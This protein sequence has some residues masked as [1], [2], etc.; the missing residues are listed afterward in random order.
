MPSPNY[1]RTIASA[2]YKG[3]PYVLGQMRFD[4][5]NWGTRQVIFDGTATPVIGKEVWL[6]GKDEA[7]GANSN[8]WAAQ[9]RVICPAAGRPQHPLNL[10]LIVTPAGTQSIQ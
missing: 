4:Y 7:S 6:E 9:V 10:Q 1:S 2:T 5:L 8:G 3:Q